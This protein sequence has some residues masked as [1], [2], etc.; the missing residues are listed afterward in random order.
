MASILEQL[1]T[2][3]EQLIQSMGYIG[4]ALLMFVENIFPPI[5]SEVVMPF[6]GSLVARGEMNMLWV[7]T[8]GTIGAL[9]GAVAIYYIGVFITE[10]RAHH[11]FKDYGKYI[12][13]SE[14]DFNKAMS[15][16]DDHGKVMVLVGRVMPTIRSLISL[17]AGLND[18][19]MGTFLFYTIL[20]TTAWNLLL[21]YGGFML[22]QNWKRIVSWVDTYG[23]V[24]WALIGLFIIYLIVRRVRQ[25]QE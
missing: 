16:F 17:P 5:P 18:M 23:Y 3:V 8:S 20:G 21:A 9:A 25:G 1:R 13:T 7:M 24:I 4:I 10:Q 22:G 15:A 11:W 6:A 2:W 12:L 14:K 19:N